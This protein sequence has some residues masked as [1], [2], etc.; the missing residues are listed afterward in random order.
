MNKDY[1]YD[2]NIIITIMI[3]YKDNNVIKIL[4]TKYMIMIIIRS[5][6]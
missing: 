1:D 2:I 6:I 5:I 3:I 4:I